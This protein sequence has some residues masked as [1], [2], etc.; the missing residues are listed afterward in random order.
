MAFDRAK[1]N[2][3]ELITAFKI[4]RGLLGNLYE[5]R[6]DT[7]KKKDDLTPNEA[8][9]LATEL[10]VYDRIT[11]TIREELDLKKLDSSDEDIDD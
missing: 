10:K 11:D 4:I 5:A 1:Y 8:F 3:K 9:Q 6:L 2:E 7:I